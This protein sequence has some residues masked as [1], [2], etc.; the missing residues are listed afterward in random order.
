METE[1][2]IIHVLLISST[3]QGNVNPMLRLGKCLASKG[4]LVTFSTPQSHGKEMLKTNP[5]ITNEPIQV[6]DG[7]LRFQFLD[8]EWDE[9]E[10]KGEGLQA[11]ANPL[12]RV[13][14]KNLL[15][16]IK[17]HEELGHPVSRL[18]N[19]PFIPWIPEVGESLGIPCALLWVQSCAITID[20]QLPCCPTLK[21]YEMPTLL[22]PTS[23]PY[24]I[25]LK[26]EMLRQ[27]KNLPNTFC[28]FMETFQDLELELIEYMSKICPIKPVGPLFKLSSILYP[29]S[30][31]TGDII[32][33]DDICMD[34]LYTQPPSSLENRGK[35]VQWSPQEHVLAHKSI[36]CFVTHCGWNSSMEAIANG[37]A[38]VGFPQ[39]GDQVIN[40][41]F[42]EDVFGVGA[43]LR[44]GDNA[45]IVLGRDEIEKCLVEVLS[46]SK[47]VEIKDNALKL[48]VKAEMV[49]ANKGSSQQNIEDFVNQLRN[50]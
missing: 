39:F 8:D 9:N 40:A 2:T 25:S 1:N 11:Y 47:G 43:R 20:V 24:T 14:K 33:A 50:L 15:L 49:V 6:G 34:W 35:F 23:P 7:K 37:V 29:D 18:I 38:V 27:Q 45:N 5:N 16:M 36:G 19:N 17:E 26:T 42:L 31:I 13:G 4:L 22:S 46:G 48:K 44:K 12:E 32:K 41:K 30:T 10:H 3:G 21:Y 28:I